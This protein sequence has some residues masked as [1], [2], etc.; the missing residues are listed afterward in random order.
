M[1]QG[2]QPRNYEKS[3]DQYHETIWNAANA[4]SKIERAVSDAREVMYS[5]RRESDPESTLH[6]MA[7]R[8]LDQHGY[9][10]YS[11]GR[12]AARTAAA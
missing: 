9:D 7:T 1:S 3:E 2:Q 6:Y 10:K 11:D 8:W 12:E 5:V 4:Y